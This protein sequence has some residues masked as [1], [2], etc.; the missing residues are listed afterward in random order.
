VFRVSLTQHLGQFLTKRS[1]IRAFTA[2][3]GWFWD[4]LED[5]PEAFGR[6]LDHGA[7][8]RLNRYGL[9]VVGWVDF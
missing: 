8:I 1:Q 5:T 6:L 4:A 2:T 3:S 9:A 7:A